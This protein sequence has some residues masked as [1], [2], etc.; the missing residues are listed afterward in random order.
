MAVTNVLPEISAQHEACIMQRAEHTSFDRWVY[1][2]ETVERIIV[3]LITTAVV[4]Q[5]SAESRMVG[6]N[7]I[8]TYAFG[9]HE[10]TVLP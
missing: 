10:H 5:P 3:V 6:T 7:D 4:R 8:H 1:V 2:A 9:P